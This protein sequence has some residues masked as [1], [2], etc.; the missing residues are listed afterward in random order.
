[1]TTKISHV[2]QEALLSSEVPF[3]N[4]CKNEYQ[5]YQLQG[6]WADEV[7]FAAFTNRYRLYADPK[8]QQARN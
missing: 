7:K 5:R 6:W 3:V 8:L 2:V 4:T 1:M